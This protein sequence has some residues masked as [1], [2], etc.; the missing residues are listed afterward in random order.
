M[1]TRPNVASE[2]APNVCISAAISLKLKQRI[3]LYLSWVNDEF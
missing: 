2:F 3:N 1:R